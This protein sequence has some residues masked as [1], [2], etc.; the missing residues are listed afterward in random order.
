M[1]PALVERHGIPFST[2]EPINEAFARGD[3]A[4]ALRRTPDEIADRFCIAGTPEEVAERVRR[5][6]FGA[7]FGHVALALAD[8]E[9]PRAW[10]GVE[11]PGLPTFRNR[12][13]SPPTA[14]C[15]S[16]PGDPQSR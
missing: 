14:C 12:S 11:I 9:I 15:R 16:S 2:I 7:G 6:I 3:V 8:A 5:D 1:P 10:A 4:E 13:G